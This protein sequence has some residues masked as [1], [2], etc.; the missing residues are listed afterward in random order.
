MHLVKKLG[1]LL[2]AKCPN[3]GRC[4]LIKM[5]DNVMAFLKLIE[6]S[7]WSKQNTLVHL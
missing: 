2:K 5:K 4:P 3:L 1:T 6:Y 7:K